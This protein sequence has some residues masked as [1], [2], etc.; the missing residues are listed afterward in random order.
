MS[1][2]ADAV[3]GAEY[4]SRSAERTNVRNG[5]RPREF[6]IRAGTLDLAIPKLRSGSYF[7]GLAARASPA[8][9][10]GA[11][12]GGGDLLPA[13][14]LDPADRGAGEELG[15]TLLAKAALSD[16]QRP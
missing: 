7:P 2:E 8:G 4:G 16:D 15:I 12:H 10:A 3:C 6:D 14:G 5:Y 13:G 9:G 1:A 11:D